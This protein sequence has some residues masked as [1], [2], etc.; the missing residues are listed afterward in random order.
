MIDLNDESRIRH[1]ARRRGFH[2]LRTRGR[3]RKRRAAM[4]QGELMLSDAYKVV[5]FAATLE[6][7][8]AF[9]EGPKEIP[10]LLH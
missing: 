2:V 4:G 9:L 10:K 1:R 8:A 5:L 7:I 3:E 6:E